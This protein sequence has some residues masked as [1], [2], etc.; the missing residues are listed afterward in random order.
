[1]QPHMQPQQ[2]PMHMGVPPMGSPHMQLS[3]PPQ[4]VHMMHPPSVPEH[5]A[6]PVPDASLNQP[7]YV[8]MRMQAQPPQQHGQQPMSSQPDSLMQASMGMPSH[9]AALVT[10]TLP[11]PQMQH[12]MQQHSQSAMPMQ[13]QQDQ[14]MR[15]SGEAME[16]P[17]VSEPNAADVPNSG[18]LTQLVAAAQLRADERADRAPRHSLDTAAAPRVRRA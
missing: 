2:H 13:Q 12:S 17:P 6:F 14:E 16:T 15:G 1:M 18:G 11:P 9:S 7:L 8:Q 10:K 5:G 3:Q 4:H